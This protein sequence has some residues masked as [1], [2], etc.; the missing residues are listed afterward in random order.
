MNYSSIHCLWGI[1][2]CR[3]GFLRGMPSFWR[4]T[5]ASQFEILKFGKIMDSFCVE[6]LR[7]PVMTGRPIDES[8]CVLTEKLKFALHKYYKYTEF[9]PGQLESLLPVVHGKDV[10]VRLAT[11]C[12]KSMCMFLVP[13]AVSNSAMAFIIS[14]LNGLMDE[15]V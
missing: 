9:R 5:V 11:G 15:Q 12:G 1:Y 6:G 7:C 4:S 13:L 14:P 2:L 8:G 3:H 10:F